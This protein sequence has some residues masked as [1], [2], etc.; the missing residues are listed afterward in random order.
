MG[1]RFSIKHANYVANLLSGRISGDDSDF[2]PDEFGSF[3]RDLRRNF[4]SS[5]P[6]FEPFFVH[7]L[8]ALLLDAPRVDRKLAKQFMER[9]RQMLGAPMWIGMLLPDR[10]RSA[11]VAQMLGDYAFLRRIIRSDRWRGPGT[12]VLLQPEFERGGEIVLENAFPVFATA[13]QSR[14]QW[15]GFLAWTPFPARGAFFPLPVTSEG[16]A[17]EAIGWIIRELGELTTRVGERGPYTRDWE[18]LQDRYL[19]TVPDAGVRSNE[20]V[21]ILHLSDLHA[22]SDTASE[23]HDGLCNIIAKIKRSQRIT[24]DLLPVVTGDLMDTPSN[25]C[26]ADARRLLRDIERECGREAIVI[27]GNHDLREGG[28]AWDN[29]RHGHRFHNGVVVDDATTGISFIC[30]NSC[31]EAALLAR[32]K[33]GGAQL[34]ELGSD[35]DDNPRKGFLRVGLVHHHPVPVS[36]PSWY[37]GDWIEKILG[38]LGKF[39]ATMRLKDADAVLKWLRHHKVGLVLHGHKHIPHLAQSDGLSIVGCGS[40][41]GKVHT[42]VRDEVYVSLN[43]LTIDHHTRRAYCEFLAERTPGTTATIQGSHEV[44][45][46]FGV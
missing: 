46:V 45:T 43:L 16:H 28:F 42:R 30:L 38:A 5:E 27:P 39:E 7:E 21:S 1:I 9:A 17:E 18:R 10:S 19:R 31:Q 6:A 41:V 36:V 22:G 20:L 34:R 3:A 13:L 4:V 15:P 26:L 37:K 8:E 29:H 25:A 35:L 14:A 2:D 12:A 32:G 33:V 23:Q 11:P 44:S 24:G 40:S